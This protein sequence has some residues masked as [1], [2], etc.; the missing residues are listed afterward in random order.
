MGTLGPLSQPRGVQLGS[1]QHFPEAERKFPSS[2]WRVTKALSRSS[3]P[4]NQEEW[5]AGTRLAMETTSYFHPM[6]A[7]NINPFQTDW[8]AI[9]PKGQS[10]GWREL[11]PTADQG[12]DPGL[13]VS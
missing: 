9:L 5:Q 4:H 6:L 11:W 3:H 10:L 13:R 12:V 8:L 2:R 7:V 1:L